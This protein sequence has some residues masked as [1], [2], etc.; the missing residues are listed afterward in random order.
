VGDGGGLLLGV[1]LQKDEDILEAAYDDRD[2]VTAEFNLN[3][4]RRMN[5]ELDADF[6]IDQFT[7][8][9]RYNQAAHRIEM[10][11]VSRRRQTVTVA[12]HAFGLAERETICTEYSHKYT[13]DGFADMAADA[14]LQLRRYWTDRRRY[15]AVLHLAVVD[16]RRNEVFHS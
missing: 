13:I 11:L 3:L 16:P 10:H 15:F 2:G 14:G 1:D 4:L 9:A 12:G 8:E 7:H 6:S 5:A